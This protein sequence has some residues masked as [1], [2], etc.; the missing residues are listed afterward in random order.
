[1]NK[2]EAIKTEKDGLDVIDD[3]ARFAAEGFASIPEDDFERLKWYGLFRRKPT[4][5]YFMVRL[6][7]PNGI[8]TSAQMR[9]LGNLTTCFGRGHADVTTRQNIQLR[10][11]TIEQA[12]VLFER[13]RMVGLTSQQSGMD[14]VRNYV[15]CP[16]AGLDPDEVLDASPLTSALQ[17]AIL[18]RRAYSNLP[19]KFNI[20]I[21]GCRQDCGHAQAND[22]GF[23]PAT[24][25]D[26]AAGFNVWVGGALG[27]KE[28][29]LGESLDAFVRPDEVVEAACRILEVFRD[30]GPR[31]SRLH[32]RLK[33]L[34]REWSIPRFRAEVERYLGRPFRPA[35]RDEVRAHGGD[36]IGVHRQR[37]VGRVYVGLTVPVGRIAGT[38]MQELARL[39]ETYG[40]GELRLTGDQ[41]VLIPHVPEAR[42][43]DLL[44]E[45]LLRD[46]SPNPHPVLRG[47]VT[48]TGNDFCHYSLIDTKGRGLELA[49]AVAARLPEL[50]PAT[51][52]RLHISGC[53]HA[54][55]Q[56]QIGDLGLQAARVRRDGVILDAA[57]VFQ[58]GRLGH[59]GRLAE[60]THDNVT[61]DEV[62][63]MV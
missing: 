31:E 23:T 2:I 15:G 1:M 63:E 13:L 19:R 38:Q 20:S 60:K 33:V 8:L 4:P 14:N 44:A 45:P 51:R 40:E 9:E 50:N 32:A 7:I 25:P 12:P 5:G 22:L 30:H 47:L 28:P 29:H 56:H 26:G 10:W 11:V 61:F 62:A 21:T 37:Q 46:L 53:P 41:N 49:Q 54:C 16:I 34:L 18:G 36:H 17:E 52:F 27:G 6:R 42:V 35:G 57:D 48:C 43:D 3:L 58:G 39:A 59:D 55:G 24:A